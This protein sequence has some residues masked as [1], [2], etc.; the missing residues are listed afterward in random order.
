MKSRTSALIAVFVFCI[1]IVLSFVGAEVL[2]RFGLLKSMHYHYEVLTTPTKNKRIL[3]LGDSFTYGNEGAAVSQ[4]QKAMEGR[5]IQFVNLGWPG[6]GPVDYLHRLRMY[7]AR[8]S[9]QWVVVNYYVG[10]DLSDTLYRDFESYKLPGRGIPWYHRSHL[11]QVIR[12][13]APFGTQPVPPAENSE[14]LPDI[15]PVNPFLLG[16]ARSHPN[17]LSDNIELDTESAKKAWELNADLLLEMAQL[18]QSWGGRL[19]IQIFPRCL[20]INGENLEFLRQLGLKVSPS[21]T[22]S[23]VIQDRI[24]ALCEEKQWACHDLLPAFKQSEASD[25]CIERD[26]HWNEQGNEFA[27]RQ[28]VDFFGR[29]LLTPPVLREGELE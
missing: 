1:S 27:Y 6:T 28:M 16:V 9:P 17:Y 20:Q 22:S 24:L 18:T 29:K 10:N 26:D 25:H 2:C 19:A 13:R 14:D 21:L 3:M 12:E 8:L 23:R 5:G 7:G 11:Y 4:L 15:L